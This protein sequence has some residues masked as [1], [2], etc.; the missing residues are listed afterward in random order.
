MPLSELK[1]QQQETAFAFLD[2]SY[3]VP[4]HLQMLAFKEYSEKNNLHLAFYGGELVGEEEKHLLLK[5]YMSEDIYTHFIFFSVRQF[6]AKNN[7]VQKGILMRAIKKQ[8]V[9]HFANEKRK[10]SNER[11]ISTLSLLGMSLNH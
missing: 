6:I 4:Q 11:D 1:M 8:M 10:V 3:K 9:F 7:E 2:S 5:A